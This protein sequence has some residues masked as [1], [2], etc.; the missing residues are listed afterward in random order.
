MIL[1]GAA[2]P[3]NTWPGTLPAH[4]NLEGFS[5]TPKI[6]AIQTTVDS[7]P[8]YQRPK[9]TG[10]IDLVTASNIMTLE[11]LAIFWTFYQTALVQGSLPFIKVHPITKVNA[12]MQFDVTKPPTV[13]MLS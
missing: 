6:N 10:S 9:S 12:V 1:G 7:G 5:L 13:V 3:A 2:T 8:V 4:F 11:E